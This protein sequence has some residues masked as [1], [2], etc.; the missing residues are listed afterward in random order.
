M[1]S[2]SPSPPLAT[3]R[4]QRLAPLGSTLAVF[5]LTAVLSSGQLYMVIPLLH[6]MAA[7]WETPQ[8]GLTWLVT[9]FGMGYAAGFLLFGPLSDRYGRKRLISFGL[10][11]AAVATALV[12]VAP[13]PEAAIALR[14]L[15]GVAV[16]I[17]PPAAMAYLAERVEPR[18]RAVA[19]ATVTSGFLAAA[20]LLQV[21][22]QALGP[23]VG[24]RGMFLVSAAAFA[25][26]A[27]AARSVMPADPPREISGSFLS[28]YRAMPTLLATPALLLRYVATV[29]ILATFVAVYTGL[30]LGGPAGIAGSPDALMALRISGLPSMVVVPLLTPLLGRVPA[31][32]R[33][34]YLLAV[35]ALA[36]AAVAV[37]GPGALWL[38]VLLAVYVLGVAA[39]APALNENIGMIAGQA[40][41]TALALFTFSLFLG[42][43]LGPQLATAFVAGGFGLLMYGLAGL[44]LLGVLALLV[45]ARVGRQ[46][47]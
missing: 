19:L 39:G 2:F 43:S 34:A 16:A 45:A 29:T 1:S 30:Q 5:T 11:A 13:G 26:V 9:V 14:A 22:A 38:A 28:A 36:L 33:A 44:L 23:I 42:G 41:G 3:A 6:D 27:L 37:T 47:G 21:A 17:F 40:R 46:A 18:R 4:S 31:P 24:W 15:Q 20:V 35:A 32:R 7:G 12:A 25:A 10:P 8:G